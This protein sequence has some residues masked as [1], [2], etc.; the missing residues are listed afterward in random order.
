MWW[1]KYL[2]VLAIGWFNVRFSF[3]FS[4]FLYDFFS[5]FSSSLSGLHLEKRVFSPSI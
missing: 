5:F 3:L 2:F 1:F 4:C